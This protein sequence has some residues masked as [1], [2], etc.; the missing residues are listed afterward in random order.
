MMSRHLTRF[1]ELYERQGRRFEIMH[2]KL[3]TT[4]GRTIV[5]IGPI[6][7]DY[8]ISEKEA[9]Q[10]MKK[11]PGSLMVKYTNGYKTSCCEDWYAVICEKYVGL[12]EYKSKH[13]K[14]INKGLKKCVIRQVD[15]DFMSQY[16]YDVYISA[17]TRYQRVIEPINKGDFV[18]MIIATKEFDDIYHYWAAFYEGKFIAYLIIVFLGNGEVD[19]SA[20]KFIPE[21]L[22][23]YPLAS[24]IHTIT[25]HYLVNLS[26]RYINA[27]LRSIYHKTDVQGVLLKKLS[28]KKE[29]L[30]LV[31]NYKQ[32]IKQFLYLTF[33][34]RKLL[35]KTNHKLH[36]LYTL[37]EIRQKCSAKVIHQ[38]KNAIV[39][40][41]FTCA[42]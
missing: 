6:T 8:S 18:K 10:L 16:G 25:H 20:G 42:S 37:E 28:F 17:F 40:D 36:S 30:N 3:W 11:F 7:L 31:I 5:P 41:N 24:L 1:A 22:N 29:P 14:E 19:I 2:D 27:G 35:S 39:R 13:R 32:F 33:P 26:M 9:Y 34:F 23:F 21:Y 12:E 15:A 4:Y 38:Q